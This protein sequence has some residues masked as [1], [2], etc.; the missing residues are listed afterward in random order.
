MLTRNAKNS[1][2]GCFIFCAILCA[3]SY[4]AVSCCYQCYCC[5]YT[6][7]LLAGRWLSLLSEPQFQ[8]LLTV[9]T[10]TLLL[11]FNSLPKRLRHFWMQSNICD[12]MGNPDTLIVWRNSS[13]RAKRLIF[14]LWFTS[15]SVHA[16]VCLPC[17]GHVIVTSTIFVE[18]WAFFGLGVYVSTR[19]SLSWSSHLSLS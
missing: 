17:F 19:L 12:R 14:F 16:C 7:W 11:K 3:I 8:D 9:R 5:C 10:I 2:C 1:P 6:A 18:R 13:W 4:C 15:L